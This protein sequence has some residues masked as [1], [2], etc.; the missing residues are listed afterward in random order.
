MKL[1][2]IFTKSSHTE[3]KQVGE[4]KHVTLSSD[5]NDYVFAQKLNGG[6]VHIRVKTYGNSVEKQ[7]EVT[8]EEQIECLNSLV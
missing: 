5:G 6:W 7:I 2:D 4:S 8:D 3:T 1:Y